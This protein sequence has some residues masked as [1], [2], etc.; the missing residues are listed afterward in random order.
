[1]IYICLESINVDKNK[2]NFKMFYKKIDVFYRHVNVSSVIQTNQVIFVSEKSMFSIC[3][4]RTIPI[5]AF[6]T[7]FTFQILVCSMKNE[8]CGRYRRGVYHALQR[9]MNSRVILT[10]GV[11]FVITSSLYLFTQQL[12][13][14][15]EITLL[16]SKP[17]VFVFDQKYAIN[18]TERR[19]LL[20]TRFHFDIDWDN[21]VR[22]ILNTSCHYKCSVTT[23]RSAIRDVDAVVFHLLDMYFWE[24]PPTYRAPHQVWVVYS[25]EP[26][27][28]VYYTG[29]S[30][31]YS[32]YIF[33]W[34][35]SFRKDAT[36]FAPYGHAEPFTGEDLKKKQ[37]VNKNYAEGKTKMTYAVISNCVDDAGRFSYVKKL[38]R[39]TPIDLYGRCGNLICPRNSSCSEIL[40][41]YK[42]AITF[43]NSNCKGY[44]SEKFWNGLFRASIPIVNWIPEQVPDDAPPKSYINV[45][46]FKSMR[47][48]ANYLDYLDKNDTEYNSYFHWHQ[49]HHVVHGSTMWN[50][51]CYLCQ[52]L[53][54]QSSPAQ[55]V[56]YPAWF[57]DDT[58]K[59]W[60]VGSS[61]YI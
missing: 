40:K 33:N 38:S 5:V 26:P 37:P 19:I 9:F 13:V 45:H 22:E 29:R 11:T 43:E 54:N 58:C 30:L 49:T 35:L 27:P 23:D 36:V 44:I 14:R 41:P 46:D 16:G 20:W 60:T 21:H 15:Y 42:F 17:H 32:K 51:F 4:F 7:P 6:I 3:R 8:H 10:I 56:D 25:A 61:Q 39:Y 2:N 52:A 1:M 47:D 48:L 34:T 28:H 31:M 18:R 57:A 53:H 50:Q 55:V 59:Q 24:P 12:P